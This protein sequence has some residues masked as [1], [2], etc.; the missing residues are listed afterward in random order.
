[1]AQDRELT[2][3]ELT[4]IFNNPKAD[5]SLLTPGEQTRLVKLTEHLDAAPATDPRVEKLGAVNRFVEGAMRTNP[6]TTGVD[7][8]SQLA[9]DPKGAGKA[10]LDPSIEY[11]N[12]AVQATRNGQP[13]AAVGEA[14][15]AVP[16]IGPYVR[17]GVDRMRSGDVAGGLGELSWLA[18]PAVKKAAGIASDA[19]LAGAKTAAPG[20]TNA[21]A[22]MLDAA[23]VDRLT[24]VMSPQVGPNK[25]RLGNQAARIAPDLLRDPDL[26]AYSRSGLA[27]KIDAKFEKAVEGLDVAAD[28]RLASQQVRTRPVLAELDKR[29]AELTATPLDASHRIPKYNEAAPAV[30]IEGVDPMRQYALRWMKDDMESIPYTSRTWNEAPRKS[31]NAAGGDADIVAGSAGARIYRAIIGS[32][33]N[34]VIKATRGEVTKAIDD[35][36]NGKTEGRLRQLVVEVADDLAKG[37]KTTRLM[38][39]SGPMPVNEPWTRAAH[40]TRGEP[41]EMPAREARPFG[42]SVEPAPNAGELAT[43]RQIRDE[44]SALGPV[45]PYESVRRIRQAWDQVAKVKYLPATA[46]DALKSRGD[47]TAAAKGASAMR[48]ALAQTDPQSAAAYQQYSL[49]KS[50]KDVIQAAEEADRVRPSRGRGM[51]RTL[52]A[53]QGLSGIIAAIVDKASD[54]A[55]TFQI[56]IAR[57]LAAVA[58]TLKAGDAAQ[59][60]AMTEQIAQSFPAV[61]TGL[62]VVGKGSAMAGRAM[63]PQALAAD[64][65]DQTEPQ[66]RR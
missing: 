57:K 16:L 63:V 44:V 9:T 52:A 61:R 4:S 18:S 28:S 12:R 21:A 40:L 10:V 29:I 2:D 33:G 14:A 31:G 50:A 13:L 27:S 62:K 26:H 8:L 19:T 37:G 39:T 11:L 51:V 30:R 5:L 45:A 48:E 54:Y 23:A 7:F 32:E 1:V 42:R 66:S 38:E 64:G 41:A 46:A 59:A 56:Q 15:S 24:K 65:Q 20:A 36:I 49:M 22:G 53:S 17:G 47:A 34:E 35:V 55:P 3:Q 58:D 25:T 6:I 43:L 60:Q